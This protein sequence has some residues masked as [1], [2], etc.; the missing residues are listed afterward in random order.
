MIPLAMMF[1]GFGILELLVI[2]ML[3]IGKLAVL[4]TV[5]YFAVKVAQGQK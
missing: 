5:V 2:A 4:F 1:Q 3:G